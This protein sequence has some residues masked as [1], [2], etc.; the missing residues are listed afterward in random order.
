MERRKCGWESETSQQVFLL[1]CLL[2]WTPSVHSL[3]GTSDRTPS[4]CTSRQRSIVS[5]TSK[6]RHQHYSVRFP[7]FDL[8]LMANWFPNNLSTRGPPSV[9]PSTNASLD[10]I[11]HDRPT[12]LWCSTANNLTIGLSYHFEQ[13]R[14]PGSARSFS[15]TFD[16]F[17]S[18]FISLHHLSC[19]NIS[20]Y[21][22]L[23]HDN[24]KGVVGHRPSRVNHSV[25]G[26]HPPRV[27]LFKESINYSRSH[28]RSLASRSRFS[29]Q[30]TIYSS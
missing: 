8:P 14:L 20:H 23:M 13:C 11:R 4:H 2:G 22:Y 29:Q 27:D 24:F 25:V 18:L 5:L 26:R 1:H 17:P 16:G 12:W 28:V 9:R 21:K 19:S 6:A 30:L 7:S 15:T 10:C 3:Y